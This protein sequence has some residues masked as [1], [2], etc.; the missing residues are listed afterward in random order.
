V[1]IYFSLIIKN[2]WEATVMHYVSS[3]KVPKAIGPYSQAIKSSGFIFLSGQLPLELESGQVVSGSV[4]DQTLKVLENIAAILEAAG[5]DISKVVKTTVFV[6][7]MANFQ[8]INKIYSQFFGEHKPARSLIEV[9]AL[10]KKEAML[11]IE[12]IAVA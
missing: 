4:E 5:S 9:S 10:P 8:A 3:D 6:T 1:I 7:D 11:E 12:A 2:V